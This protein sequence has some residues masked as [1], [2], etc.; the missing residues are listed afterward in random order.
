MAPVRILVADDHEV[1]RRG[2]R[3]LLEAEA[4]WVVCGEAVTGREAHRRQDGQTGEEKQPRHVEPVHPVAAF[5]SQ[6]AF[7][8]PTQ[9][10]GKNSPGVPPP[11]VV[12][13]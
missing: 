12:V 4:N 2:V 9:F 13:N 6:G 5:F 3:A 10:I 8:S 7:P 1:V 11:A